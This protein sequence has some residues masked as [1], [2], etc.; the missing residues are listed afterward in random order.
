MDENKIQQC[1]QCSA[2]L[3]D[4]YCEMRTAD[5]MRLRLCFACSRKELIKKREQELSDTV[6]NPDKKRTCL[7]LTQKR[8]KSA[9]NCHDVTSD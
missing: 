5:G 6:S 8:Q 3:V 2:A 7:K 1:E 4:G 9:V